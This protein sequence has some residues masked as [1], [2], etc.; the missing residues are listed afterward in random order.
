M[1]ETLEQQEM[2][3]YSSQPATITMYTHEFIHHHLEI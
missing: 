1:R 2:T 3:S